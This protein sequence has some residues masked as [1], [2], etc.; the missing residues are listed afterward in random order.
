MNRIGYVI[1]GCLVLLTGCGGANTDKSA[2]AK[3]D[4][5]ESLEDSIRNIQTTID[6]CNSQISILR[7]DIESRLPDFVTVANPREVGS[8]T[9][10]SSWRDKYPLT[11]TGLI[12]RLDANNRFELVA[13]LSGKPFNRITIQAPDESV[14]TDVVQA[15]QALNYQTGSLTT[16]L[17]TGEVAD[18]VGQLIADNELNP[19]TVIFDNGSPVSSWKL[20][21]GNSKMISYTYAL[22]K[23]M[24]ELKRLENQVPMLN[25]KIKII[26]EHE[27]K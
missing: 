4:Y 5:I 17:F 24:K 10:M 16:V 11:S 26:R 20:P 6:S 22:S 13:A 8:Y 25:E 15:D 3:Q 23:D 27:N 7:E 1:A 2:K 14:S 21:A 12:A 9:I 18:L 19:L